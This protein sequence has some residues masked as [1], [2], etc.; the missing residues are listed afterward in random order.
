M[1]ANRMFFGQEAVDRW[2][3]SGQVS[4]EGEVLTLRNGPRFRLTSGV[5]FRV[6]VASGEDVLQLC[7]KAKTVDEVA[8]MNGELVTG[9]VL[10]GDHAYEVT[11]GFLAELLDAAQG[12]D[13]VPMVRRLAEDG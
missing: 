13:V 5:V 8:A 4:L 11:D 3:E 12:G 9:S 1:R 2:L 10:I 6:E 7:G